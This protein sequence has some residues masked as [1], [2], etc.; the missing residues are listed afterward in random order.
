[1]CQCV[2]NSTLMSCVD[3]HTSALTHYMRGLD[4]YIKKRKE[5]TDKLEKCQCEQHMNVPTMFQWQNHLSGRYHNF[6]EA[7][8]CPKVPHPSLAYNIGSNKKNPRLFKWG[9]IN[10]TCSDCG[11]KKTID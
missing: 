6:I 8:C 3:I 5:V 2:Q 11:I 7:T 1:M 4:T 9:C 10:N